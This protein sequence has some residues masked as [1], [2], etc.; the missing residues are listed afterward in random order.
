MPENLDADAF[1][2]MK[3]SGETW[4]I[5]FWAEW[6]GPCKQ[7]EPIFKEVS[8][9]VEGINFG[10]IDIEANQDLATQNGVRSIPTFMV[11]K[12]G[13]VVDQKMGA[14]PK[15]QFQEWVESHV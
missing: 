9:D 5:D 1:Q 8:E 15:D 4:V 7:M 10:K 6:C 3:E 2:Q 13:D 11:F 12:D 14:M